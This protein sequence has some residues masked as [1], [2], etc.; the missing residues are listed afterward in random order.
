M[1]FPPSD[2]PPQESLALADGRRLTYRRI[3]D[4]DGKP[5]LFFHGTPGS[6]MLA[7]IAEKAAR[8]AGYLMIAPD[9][10]GIGDSDL[11]S[12]RE[13]RYWPLDVI[14]LLKHLNIRECG[15]IAISGGAPYAFQCAYDLPNEITFI[16]SLSGWMS[17]GREEAHNIPLSKNINAFRLMYKTKFSVPTIGKLTEYTIQKHPDKLLAHLRKTLPPAD[18]DLLEDEFSRELFL[19]DLQNA[20]KHGWQGAAIDGALQFEDQ[21]FRLTAVKQPVIL[22]HGTADTI[23]PCEMARAYKHHLPNVAEYIE[24][25]EGGHLCAIPEAD[26]VFAGIGKIDGHS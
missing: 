10:P 21:P 25:P 26:R 8:K 9:R 16:A 14:Q 13:V 19:Y 6:H 5:V 15:I 23:V 1:H 7:F 24:V 4:P 22:L 20:Y 17:Y 12:G 3:G 2:W 18:L 11:Q